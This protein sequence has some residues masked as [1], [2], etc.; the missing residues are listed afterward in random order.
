MVN[1]LGRGISS[2]LNDDS[3]DESV[4][5]SVKISKISP[6]PFQ[7]RRTFDDEALSS[8]ALSIK[9]KGVLQP[10]IVREKSQ[11]L[12]EL[13]AG[14]RRLRASKLAGLTEIPII[15]SNMSDQESFEAALLENIQRENLNPIEEAEAYDRL[16]KEFGHTQDNVA[17]IT[18]KSR[19]HIANMLRIL[20]LDDQ[21]KDLLLDNSITTGHAKVLVNVPHAVDVANEIVKNNLSVRETEKIVAKIKNSVKNSEHQDEK[22]EINF[23]VENSEDV[24]VPII[25]SKDFKIDSF[26][27]N[28]ELENFSADDF[29]QSEKKIVAPN[30]FH[31]KE[32]AELN[33][34]NDA[35]D[36]DDFEIEN[37]VENQN[38]KDNIDTKVIEN[39]L[40]DFLKTN[41]RIKLNGKR[42][43]VLVYFN[44][45]VDFDRLL[46]KI[47]HSNI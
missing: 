19:S 32:N 43:A 38:S 42:G 29:P 4:T 10:I 44:D 22:F 35:Y 8:L 20:T 36:E 23:N 40:A 37:R 15:I 6:N 25:N 39:R 9:E 13:I 31:A 30:E 46:K 1:S 7:P 11:G 41:V 26:D 14:E 27:E 24:L 5:K 3:D 16:M 34:E 18:G 21:I 2:F 33:D 45:F 12:Y 47:M 28:Q 17:K